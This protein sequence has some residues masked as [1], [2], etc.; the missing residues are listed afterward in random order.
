MWDCVESMEFNKKVWMTLINIYTISRTF[1]TFFEEIL[2]CF[3]EVFQ[4]FTNKKLIIFVEKKIRCVFIVL[5]S[6][7]HQ[8]LNII[9]FH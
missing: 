7:I 6:C 8:N 4:P 9:H 5:S 3:A 2:Y 1:N